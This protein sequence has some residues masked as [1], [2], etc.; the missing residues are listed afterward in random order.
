[1][2]LRNIKKILSIGIIAFNIGL[3]LLPITSLAQN[4]FNP[5]SVLPATDENIG[6]RTDAC[7]GL[8]TMI[9]TGEIALRNI[10]CFIKFFT[11]T[12]ITMAGSLAVVFV[13]I[14]GYRY[15]IGSDQDKDAAK[16]TITYALIGLIVTLAAWLIVDL[17]LQF[18]TE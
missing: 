3:L 16:K 10:P 6:G 8:S 4:N 17:V 11:Q 13:M 15:V 12:L 5:P 9:R 18:A 2:K 14:G 7:V 1:M